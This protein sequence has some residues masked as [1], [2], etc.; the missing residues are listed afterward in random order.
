[1]LGLAAP[2]ALALLLLIPVIWWL[3][4]RARPQGD[5]AFS[6]FFLVAAEVGEGR[7]GPRLR[8]PLLLLVRLISLAFLAV[9]AAGPF[10]AGPRGTL[11][12]VAG[13]FEPDAAWEAPVTVVRAG[14]PP[15]VVPAGEAVRPVAALPDWGS[16]L[17]LGSRVAPGA[18]VVRP[19]VPGA[20][21][22]IT[23]GAAAVDGA[24]VVVTATVVG[25]GQPALV[26]GGR[27]WP[28]ERRQD[29]WVVRAEGLPAGGAELVLP[30]AEAW[31]VCLPD[32]APLP[33]AADGWPAAVAEVLDIFQDLQR[34]P[35]EAAVWRP[36]VAPPG[37]P[38]WAA[39]APDRTRF[40]FG[41]GV[42]SEGPAPLLFARHHPPPGAVA[43]RWHPLAEAADV[44]V[45][46]GDAPVID[47]REGP[48]GGGVRFGFLPE[49]TDLPATA[50]WPVLFADL[51]EAQRW[52]RA[53]CRTQVAGRSLVVQATAAVE[54]VDPAG[55]VRS[56]TPVAGQVLVDGLDQ[57]GRYHL[58]SAGVEATVAV[59]PPLATVAPETPPLAGP[60]VAAQPARWPWIAAGLLALASALV[61]A[62]RVRAPLGWLPLALAGVAL[63][64]PTWGGAPGEVVV[65]VD[66][67]ASMPGAET[68]AVVAAVRAQLPKEIK[69]I[70]GGE[71]VERVHGGGPPGPS[72]GGTHHQPLLAAAA[73][74]AGPGG[75]VVL[76]SDGR[77]DDGPVGLAVPIV[78]V[79]V[80]AAGPDAR[81]VGARALRLGGQVFVR[82]TVAA[83]RPTAATVRLGSAAVAVALGPTERSVQA[84]LPAGPTEV[85]VSVE[86]DGDP[87]AVNDRLPVPVEG[88][89]PAQAVVVGAGAVGFAESAGLEARELPAAAL[90]ESG[91]RLGLLRAT[92]LH[93]QP[94]AVFSPAVL[95]GLERWVAAGGVLVLSG[96]A[97]AFG[98]GGWA[99][100]ALDALSPLRADPRPPGSEVAV[101]LALDCS[102]SM[103]ETAGGIGPEGVGQLAASVAAALRPDDRV[104][105][106]AFGPDA[107]SLLAPTPVKRLQ[108]EGLQVPTLARGGTRLAPALALAARQLADAEAAERVLVIISDGQ[109]VD[110]DEPALEA[111]S[112]ALEGA[113]IR[114]VA[115]LTGADPTREPLAGLAR[116]TG[117]TVVTAAGA[118]IERFAA[119]ST[120]GALGDGLFAPGGAVTARA[121]W[122]ARVGGLPPP[123]EQR[124]RAGARPEARV[125]A[126]VGGEPLL[127]E[128]SFGQ[129]RVIA[130]ATDRWALAADQWAALLAPAA[131]PRLADA[132]LE[133][134]GDLLVY[135]GV[136]GDA[137]PHGVAVVEGASGSEAVAWHPVGPGRAVAPLP[138]GPVE[139]LSITSPSPRGAVQARVTRGPPAE[140][141]ATGADRGALAL[142][143][144]LTGGQVVEA[145]GVAA[146]VQAARGRQRGADLAPWLLLLAALAL[147]L[148]TARWA[149]GRG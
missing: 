70:E 148:D 29:D 96:R 73:G 106:L 5:R 21:G 88:G 7:A 97:A 35:A 113:H 93:D 132:H 18:R 119:A 52:T 103:A 118:D 149:G 112:A 15:T 77:A 99:G 38:G 141:A 101:A 25:E 128:W 72:A 95:D 12:L 13:P 110:A 142:Q 40:E 54:L 43:R 42:A 31:P 64:G 120:L 44:L 91:A 94:A 125:L 66:T 23:S 28:L 2:V 14:Q 131:A 80:A 39:F 20:A 47:R 57:Q 51:I 129:G 122:P 11:V 69:Q 4:R 6:A 117:G 139:V 89:E 55:Q 46:A 32:M 22:L 62:R 30:G 123:V 67:S 26:A 41:A 9:A 78:A 34:V 74:L 105:V 108:I 127:A 58:R 134:Q 17:L 104:S 98:P 83:D 24:A 116:R 61:L 124:V 85:E 121:G 140:V 79:P 3:H 90:A 92:F 100:T 145:A 138:A 33:V 37:G 114:V 133:V 60:T 48:A 115:V 68:A 144:Q 63:F 36:G 81:I 102:G 82:A 59:V 71:R 136:A 109:V 126:E 86:A 19:A 56:L 137:P 111:A 27:T 10:W 49:D 135:L 16:A 87:V 75:V 107:Q 147:L 143:A 130:L 84:V 65:A 45:F 53:R 1:M 76:V 50:G 8:A 146:A